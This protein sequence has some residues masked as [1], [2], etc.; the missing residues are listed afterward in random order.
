MGLASRVLKRIARY[1]VGHVI[2]ETGFNVAIDAEDRVRDAVKRHAPMVHL[3]AHAHT[4]REIRLL[5]ERYQHWYRVLVRLKKDAQEH[6]SETPFIRNH[7]IEEVLTNLFYCA[8]RLNTYPNMHWEH[9]IPGQTIARLVSDYYEALGL[10][11]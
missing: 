8:G 11:P 4:E 9:H 6:E 3:P 2:L 1:P 5:L 7:P 10:K